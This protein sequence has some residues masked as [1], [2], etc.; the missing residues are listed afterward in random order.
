MDSPE[1]VLKIFPL[2]DIV[3]GADGTAS[4]T[5][6]DGLNCKAIGK[7]PAVR[8]RLGDYDGNEKGPGGGFGIPTGAAN[9]ILV[10][11]GDIK[12]GKRPDGEPDGTVVNGVENLRAMGPLPETHTVRSPSGSV[13]FYFQ[14]PPGVCIRNSGGAL[15]PCVDVRG[16]GGFVVGEG[17]PHKLG[18]VYEVIVD[19]AP[20]PLPPWL[21]EKLLAIETR[22]G[23]Q[24]VSAKDTVLV[25]LAGRPLERAV[26]WARAYLARVPPCI[27]DGS[28]SAKLT[29]YAAAIRAKRIPVATCQALLEEVFNPRC[30]PLWPVA[31]LARALA[32]AER[33]PVVGK[34]AREAKAAAAFATGLS[35]SNGAQPSTNGAAAGAEA[36]VASTTSGTPSDVGAGS[37]PT[38]GSDND[39]AKLAD[40]V[41]QTVAENAE[42][43]HDPSETAYAVVTTKGVRRVLRLRSPKM[44]AWIARTVHAD[45]GRSVSKNAIDQ[46][47]CALEGF[48]V[49]DCDEREVHLRVAEHE[50]GIYIDIGG[51]ADECIEVTATGWRVLDAAPV[52]FRRPDAMRALP[53]PVP[54]GT[55][56]DLRPFVN[57]ADDALHLL[58]AWIV[59]A[60]CPGR[61]FPILAL[62]GEMGTAKSTTARVARSLVD[63]NKSPVRSVPRS[64]DDLAVAAAHSHVLAYDNL[65]GVQRWLSDALCR[66]ATGGGLSKRA[67]YTND[68]EV[69]LDA[70][71]PVIVNGIEDI[72]NR[73][74]LADRCLVLTLTPI[75]KGKRRAERRF[76]S[77]F[78]AAAPRIFGYLLD[79]VSSAIRELPT[80]QLA[81]LPRMAD[82]A[83]WILGAESGLKL[84]PGTLLAA[85]DRNRTKVMDVALDASPVATAVRKLLDKNGGTWTG[86]PS[87]LLAVLGQQF[88]TDAVRKDHAWPKT[89]SGL[90]GQ[91]RR[92]ATFLRGVG[93]MLDLDDSEGR[94]ADKHRV[95][96]LTR[97]TDSSGVG[98]ERPQPEAGTRGDD[99]GT[100]ENRSASPLASRK[101]ALGDAGTL[102]TLILSQLGKKKEW[103][104]EE[105]AATGRPVPMWRKTSSPASPRPPR[106]KKRRARGDAPRF[107]CVPG[108]VPKRP[109][110]RGCA[111]AAPPRRST[112]R[113]GARSAASASRPRLGT[114]LGGRRNETE[115]AGRSPFT[116]PPRVRSPTALSSTFR[117]VRRNNSPPLPSLR[118]TLRLGADVPGRRSRRYRVLGTCRSERP[119]A[120]SGVPRAPLGP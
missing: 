5:C 63:P 68:E 107:S 15:G 74:D 120:G 112:S 77:D 32:S 93:V 24:T 78:A 66:L 17:S 116:V 73:D 36:H 50:G 100:H 13:H 102:G 2:R 118:R 57:A 26:S 27:E 61:P 71:R 54:G 43:F 99:A 56:D 12:S 58:I 42:L 52:L 89:P 40:Q 48:A 10:I 41:I 11:E 28:S 7:H 20:A 97:A 111:G 59:T 55:L 115:G 45:L 22:R 70:I 75:L 14:P 19:V 76:W 64:E 96:H 69:V 95:W 94:G 31:D 67:H 84:A 108:A 79:G 34:V 72:A 51:K 53:R 35:R 8:W 1:R 119:A 98:S 92:S 46:A 37:G 30:V 88:V 117:P 110:S 16:E 104:Q 33:G 49:H 60:F 114:R 113:A 85:Y 83:E 25:D 38:S 62:H 65:S 21:L 87:E 6:S 109:H 18:G 103:A 91:L 4:C 9:G 39:K 101:M 105:P 44:H 90:S 47:L 3:R 81:E 82:F 86:E 23:Q 106:L 80:V 29:K